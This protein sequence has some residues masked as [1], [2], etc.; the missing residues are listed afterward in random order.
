[1]KIRRARGRFTVEI[2]AEYPFTG[3]IDAGKM[4]D[5]ISDILWKM[6][7]QAIKVDVGHITTKTDF[8][9]DKNIDSR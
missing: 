3:I 5:A 6:F 9:R 4:E 2:P 1:M 7:P 8:A